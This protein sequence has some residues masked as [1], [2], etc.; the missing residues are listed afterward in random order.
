VLVADPGDAVPA[1]RGRA[2]RDLDAIPLDVIVQN[3]HR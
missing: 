1:V 3:R 2:D